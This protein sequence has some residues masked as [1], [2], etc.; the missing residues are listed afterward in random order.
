VKYEIGVITGNKSYNKSFSKMIPGDD[1]GRVS[2][3]RAKLNEMKDFLVV[4]DSHLTIKYD[5]Y[6]AN[7]TIYFLQNGSFDWKR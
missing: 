2:T 6:V 7:Q 4:N 1:D 3:E 5:K